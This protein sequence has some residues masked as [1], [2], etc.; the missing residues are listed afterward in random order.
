VRGEDGLAP[1]ASGRLDLPKIAPGESALVALPDAVRAAA[2]SSAASGER[3]LDVTFSSAAD[4][5]WAPAGHEVAWAQFPLDPGEPT[6]A[7][8]TAGAPARPV[9]ID[10]DSATTL[11]LSGPDFSLVFDRVRG[12]IGSWRHA[13]V[14]L[15]RA[16][17]RLSF[18]R[19]PT[20]ND[21]GWENVAR[22]WRSAGLDRLQHR[23]DAFEARALPGGGAAAVTITAR[24]APP[25]AP[26]AFRCRYRYVLSGD[27]TVR[28]E[29]NGEPEGEWPKTLPRIAL[30]LHLPTGLDTVRWFGLG[31][32][33][34]Y[35]DSR[36]A[37]RLGLWTASVDDLY[38]PYVFPQE[39]GN[40]SDTR[41]AEFRDARGAGLS[42]AGAPRFDFSAHRFTPE[43]FDAAATRPTWCRARS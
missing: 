6:A 5:A 40:R 8:P 27:G 13:G 9:R 29:V 38:T 3:W 12:V 23:I 14:D 20:D 17:P 25:A 11:T 10:A 22:S 18:W 28:I 24:I 21:R 30:R 42:V 1:L 34:S 36:E 41:W 2:A 26:R 43:D 16:G 19:A 33:E 39:N 32:G 35:P 15:L 31:P 37:A 7:A 4:T